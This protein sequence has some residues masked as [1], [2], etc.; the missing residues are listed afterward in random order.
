M[1]K[2]EIPIVN[3][4]ELNEVD[5]IATSDG[6]AQVRMYNSDV[7]DNR[8]GNSRGPWGSDSPWD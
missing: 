3:V 5:V 4:I 1:K 7:E 8:H 6:D 2:F